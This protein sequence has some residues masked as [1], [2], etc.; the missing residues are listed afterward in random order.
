MESDE[1]LDFLVEVHMTKSEKWV[2]CVFNLLMM[3]LIADWNQVVDVYLTLA[4]EFDLIST[5]LGQNV[6]M[7]VLSL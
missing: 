5:F 1:G 4:E 6:K 7:V 3:S 2:R